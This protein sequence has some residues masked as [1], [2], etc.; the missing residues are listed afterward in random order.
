MLTALINNFWKISNGFDSL[1]CNH[2]IKFSDS[3]SVFGK[4]KFSDFRVFF[5][6]HPGSI[7]YESGLFSGLFPHD[8]VGIF[9]LLFISNA[10]QTLATKGFFNRFL[11]PIIKTRPVGLLNSFPVFLASFW[12]SQSL[13]YVPDLSYSFSENFILTPQK[14]EKN[15]EKQAEKRSFLDQKRA[16]MGV[17]YENFILNRT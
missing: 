3:D 10:P 8:P 11:R 17:Q 7:Q 9:P 15:G 5:N 14:R 2:K 13:F 6:I 16:K 4:I 12:T 1:L